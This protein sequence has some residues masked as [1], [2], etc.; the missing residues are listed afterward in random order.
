MAPPQTTI[1]LSLPVNSAGVALPSRLGRDLP[2]Q[3]INQWPRHSGSAFPPTERR[4][5][6]GVTLDRGD[7]TL[8]V[9]VGD[10]D[11]DSL[12]PIGIFRGWQ[13]QRLGL[14]AGCQ[15]GGE[16]QRESPRLFEPEQ[17]GQ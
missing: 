7:P 3:R 1:A 6:V 5:F 15:P 4:W 10:A 9:G 12:N 11:H 16:D 14:V 17:R 2:Q 13:Q 8:V